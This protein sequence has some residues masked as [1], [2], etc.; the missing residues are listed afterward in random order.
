MARK[1][2]SGPKQEFL[3]TPASSGGA[4]L[5]NKSMF[6]TPPIAQVTGEAAA[7]SALQE[8]ADDMGKARLEGRMV[9]QVARGD[10]IS[11][12]LTRD[13][14]LVDDE[15]MQALIASIRTHGQRTPIEITPLAGP[16]GKYGLISGWRRLAALEHLQK[17]TGDSR[18]DTVLALLRQPKD[19]AD[20]YVSM[21]EENEIR[22]GLSYYERARIAAIA[23]ERGVFET[24]KQALLSL[25]AAA[26]R[27]KRS[28]IRSFIELYHALDGVLRFPAALKERQGLA[29]VEALR[30]DE[31][32]RARI[33]R[34]LQ[35]GDAET[36]EAEQQ[37]IA[38]LIAPPKAPAKTPAK[39][40]PQENV[41]HAEHLQV[42]ISEDLT[43]SLT[44]GQIEISGAEVSEKLF[45]QTLQF[46]QRPRN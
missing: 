19:A 17:Q 8:L 35:T 11:D 13:R 43:L 15:D 41:P 26:S 42:R 4:G 34:G 36:A 2:L 6:G 45:H 20:A 14:V 30:R 37:L 12:H 31:A 24:E 21:V 5:E 16:S 46:L 23:T 38:R 29:L 3:G 39:S 7:Q 22:V 27:A 28:R 44:N 33:I 40:A 25:F 9:V 18:F 10:I 1:R 32:T